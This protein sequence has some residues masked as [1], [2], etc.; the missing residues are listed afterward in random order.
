[1]CT[2]YRHRPTEDGTDEKSSSSMKG[3]SVVT[4]LIEMPRL[5]LRQTSTQ[6]VNAHVLNATPLEYKSQVSLGFVSRVNPNG[7]CFVLN[8][9]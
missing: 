7:T 1:M 8:G 3:F 6:T 5:S 9:G 2:T 4:R